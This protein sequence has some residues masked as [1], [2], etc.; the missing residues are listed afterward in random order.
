MVN[1]SWLLQDLLDAAEYFQ[2][3]ELKKVCASQLVSQVETQN[4]YTISSNVH[5]TFY[6]V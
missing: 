2:V 5:F 3:A 1:S 6:G 4:S